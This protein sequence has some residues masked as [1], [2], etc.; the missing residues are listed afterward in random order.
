[1][2]TNFEKL[3]A[4]VNF[5]RIADEIDW[6]F[7]N[8]ILSGAVKVSTDAL[9]ILVELETT[10]CI[11]SIEKGNSKITIKDISVP[12][13]V[14][15]QINVKVSYPNNLFCE[16]LDK[17]LENYKNKWECPKNFYI[18][19]YDYLHS[20]KQKKPT[21]I[22]NYFTA[23]QVV[24]ILKEQS[25]LTNNRP[26][27]KLYFLTNQKI[28]IEI[29]YELK[30][31]KEL[32]DLRFINFLK[33][34]LNDPI[35]KGEKQ[36]I[37]KLNLCKVLSNKAGDCK[38]SDFFKEIKLFYNN[39]S[40]DYELF[41]SEF[42][43]EKLVDEIEAKRNE[44][45]MKLNNAL[46]SIQGKIL[47]IPISLILIANQINLGDE[48]IIKNSFVII[49]ALVFIVLMYFL[50]KTQ[51]LSLISVKREMEV[52]KTNLR[53]YSKSISEKFDATFKELNQ[54]FSRNRL[55]ILIIFFIALLSFAIT[56]W[57]YFY[58]TPIVWHW[59]CDNISIPVLTKLFCFYGW[60][61]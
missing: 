48:N 22:K 53:Q 57:V 60:I 50:F 25:D 43:F 6:D 46:S 32:C 37:F 17:F 8:S 34:T 10:D 30:D 3:T 40:S 23:L 31:I 9:D 27:L 18:A 13:S 7:V 41:V 15:S 14:G 61:T 36:H 29:K 21:D 19:K 45:L 33:D 49:G 44:F 2:V 56:L 4:C 20:E 55:I 47:A 58:Y 54:N 26:D 24:N 39:F 52:A 12:E 42:S 1:M 16:N 38:I 28:E 59:V 35:H 5:I 11:E 51:Y